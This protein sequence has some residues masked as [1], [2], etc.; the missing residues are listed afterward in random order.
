MCALQSS[1]GVPSPLQYTIAV[2]F[3]VLYLLH[4]VVG[5]GFSA[6]ARDFL[7][8]QARG[9]VREVFQRPTKLHITVGMMK[10]FSER[11]KVRCRLQLQRAGL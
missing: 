7:V 9:V 10:L 6:I 3:L 4:P 2:V 11:E 5:D 1:R 8:P